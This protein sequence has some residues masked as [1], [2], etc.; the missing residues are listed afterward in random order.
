VVLGTNG[1]GVD[2]Q[3]IEVA[4]H[5]GVAAA[6]TAEDAHPHEPGAVEATALCPPPHRA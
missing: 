1:V 4:A 6:V 5:S 2:Q 3:Q